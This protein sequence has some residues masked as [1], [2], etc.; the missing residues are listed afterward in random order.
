MAKAPW[1]AEPRRWYKAKPPVLL[2]SSEAASSGGRNCCKGEAARR[3]HHGATRP[4]RRCCY[5]KPTILRA[6]VVAT[7]R[8]GDTAANHERPEAAA[9]LSAPW[10]LSCCKAVDVPCYEGGRWRGEELHAT[11]VAAK[12][13]WGGSYMRWS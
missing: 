1:E 13:L 8:G 9:N 10:P 6:A 3:C 12:E 11:S 7:A 5:N 2:Q 4:G